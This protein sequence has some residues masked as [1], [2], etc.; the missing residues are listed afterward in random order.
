MS[1]YQEQYEKLKEQFH[2]KITPLYAIFPWDD[3]FNDTIHG[4]P[5]LDCLVTDALN[6]AS[7]C[8][9]EIIKAYN[10]AISMERIIGISYSDHIKESDEIWKKK[11]EIAK[12]ILERTDS[13]VEVILAYYNKISQK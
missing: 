13:F 4:S 3:F 7:P 9:A 10:K 6:N 11:T 12:I 8:D 2:E 1:T 5:E